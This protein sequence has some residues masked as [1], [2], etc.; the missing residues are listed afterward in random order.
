MPAPIRRPATPRP[1]AAPGPGRQ[2]LPERG[3]QE[4]PERTC[5]G[6]ETHGLRAPVSGNKPPQ[7]GDVDG[8]RCT[9][10]AEANEDAALPNTWRVPTLWEWIYRLE[11]EH[12]A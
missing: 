6:R 10:E 7:S 1:L 4:L 11:K 5:S 2:G 3:E 9:G 12:G 8:E